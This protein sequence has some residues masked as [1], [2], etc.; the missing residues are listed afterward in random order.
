MSTTRYGHTATLLNDGRVLVVGG[1]STPVGALSDPPADTILSSAEVYDSKTNTWSTVAPMSTARVRHTAT[2]L[3]DGRVLVAGGLGAS[4]PL[5]S[6]ELFDP[7]SNTWSPGPAM[8]VA[9][10]RHTA[11]L[12]SDGRVLAAGG[13]PGAVASAEIYDPS[14]NAWTAVASMHAGRANHTATLLKDGRVLVVGGGNALASAELF[15][16]QANSWQLAASLSVGRT[17]HSATM[18][19]SGSVLVVGG[20]GGGSWVGYVKVAPLAS[21]E[22]YDPQTNAWSTQGSLNAARYGQ[23][24][25][26]LPNGE[27][28]GICGGGPA[29][30][31]PSVEIFDPSSGTWTAAAPGMTLSPDGHTTT[32]LPDGKLLITGGETQQ[33]ALSSSEIFIP[34]AAPRHAAAR[35]TA[36]IPAAARLPLAI[37]LVVLLLA[38]TAVGIIVARRRRRFSL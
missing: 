14:A 20:L 22:L 35:A 26:Q 25:T 24:A 37:G 17:F 16:P 10:E 1:A 29:G 31:A 9:R 13:G 15:D 38:G 8:G 34:P 33:A 28:V 18:L 11:T 30:E 36:F 3:K 21:T 32:L 23:T 2:L 27:V 6:T 12:L 5:S 7:G 19:S 4:G